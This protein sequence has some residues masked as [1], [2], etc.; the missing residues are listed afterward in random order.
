LNKWRVGLG[1]GYNLKNG[2]YIAARTRIDENQHVLVD[3]KG[4]Y[5]HKKWRFF[6]NVAL[7]LNNQKFSRFNFLA[8]HIDKEFDFSLAHESRH[9][10]LQLGR[11]VASIVYKNP[12]YHAAAQLRYK[13][14]KP[15]FVLGANVPVNNKVTLKAKVTASKIPKLS[16]T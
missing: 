7:N 3:W 9:S 5:I 15:R 14:H 10:H 11:I 4:M 1:L 8:S 16:N 6:E 13:G 2:G 12:N